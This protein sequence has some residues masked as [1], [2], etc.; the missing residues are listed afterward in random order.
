MANK[1]IVDSYRFG[2]VNFIISPV[3]QWVTYEVI[4]VKFKTIK[5]SP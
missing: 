1:Y 5:V 2:K 3:T 4:A